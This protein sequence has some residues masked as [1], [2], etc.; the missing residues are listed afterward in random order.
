MS[1]KTMIIDGR[2]VPVLPAKVNEIIKNKRT[3]Q[4]YNSKDEFNTDVANPQTDT[5]SEDFQK[6]VSITVASLNVFGKTK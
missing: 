4:V 1:K 2:E 3:G 5:S 6:D